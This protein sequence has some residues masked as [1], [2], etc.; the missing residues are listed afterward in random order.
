MP[1]YYEPKLRADFSALEKIARGDYDTELSAEEKALVTQVPESLKPWFEQAVINTLYLPFRGVM[2][3]PHDAL[4]KL[5]DEFLPHSNGQ[6][7][8]H[9]AGGVALTIRGTFELG[10]KNSRY[11]SVTPPRY[12]PFEEWV[13]QALENY[14]TRLKDVIE[15]SFEG[16]MPFRYLMTSEIINSL[17]SELN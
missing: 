5:V 17:R 11:I 3:N 12:M 2:K 13:Q 14:A 7:L 16:K 15:R 9:R 1:K 4:A 6:K 8:H 10:E